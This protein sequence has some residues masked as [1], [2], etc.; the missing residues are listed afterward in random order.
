MNSLIF[1]HHAKSAILIGLLLTLQITAS[2]QYETQ[3]S[4]ELVRLDKA[5]PGILIDLR[6]AT[7]RNITGSPFYPS[8]V[9]WLR[10]EAAKKLAR[11]QKDLKKFKLQLIIWDA[12]RPPWAQEILWNAFPDAEF[13]APPSKISRHARGTTV[14]IG[15]ADL[16][17]N[18]AATPT[19]FDTFSKKAD[20]HLEDVSQPA[21]KNTEVLRALMFK[22]GFSGVPAE[23]WHYDL[24]DWR[25]YDIIH[26]EAPKAA[27]P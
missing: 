27:Q 13:V 23:W 12:W 16:E 10:P 24:R 8:G 2:A 17:G 26:G 5:I 20:H 22:H 25:K 6:Y 4:K 18:L 19:D 21:R 14:D 11:V 3:P 9:A 1:P 15:L 7:D